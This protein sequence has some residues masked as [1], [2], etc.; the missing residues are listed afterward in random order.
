MVTVYPTVSGL[1]SS[2]SGSN[3][4]QILTVTGTGFNSDN[5][6]LNTVLLQG[7]ACVILSCTPTSIT[8][9]VAPAP[10][11]AL[12]VGP[13][14]GTRGLLHRVYWNSGLAYDINTFIS[15]SVYPNS[16][17]IIRNQADGLTGFCVDCADAY[18]QQLEGFFVPKVTA[19]HRFYIV[20]DDGS[21]LF[22]SMSNLPSNM[23]RIAFCGGY[24]PTYWFNMA[25]QIS[26]PLFLQ[27][28]KPYFMRARQTEGHGGDWLNVAV[29]IVNYTAAPRSDVDLLLHSVHERQT[30]T[31]STTVRRE[32]QRL[33]FT[34]AS[35][36]FMFYISD[37]G[38]RSALVNLDSTGMDPVANAIAVSFFFVCVISS[39]FIVCFDSL[40]KLQCDSPCA[41]RRRS[42]HIRYH[43]QLPYRHAVPPNQGGLDRHDWYHLVAACA[44][45]ITARSR[46][47]LARLQ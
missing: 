18:G 13:Y 47:I 17:S 14:A 4:G 3:G 30:I 44:D 19:F 26:A 24:S 10:V 28:G 35:G 39:N 43:H 8:C 12:S 9:S 46:Y 41:L 42:Y 22:F 16:P 7:V 25:Q 31:I 29:R 5:C 40:W 45:G 6:S 32:I 2:V 27:A 23:T 1:S 37:F 33:N 36:R 34:A 38:A 15:S 21:D 20:S 11:T